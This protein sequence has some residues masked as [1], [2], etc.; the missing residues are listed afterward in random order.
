[1]EITKD[2]VVSMDYTL[3]DD[4]GNVLDSSEGREALSFVFGNGMIIPGLEKAIEGKSKGDSLKVSVEPAE[5]YG[6]YNEEA[7][8]SVNKDSFQGD[9]ELQVGMQVQAR[10]PN[11]DIQHL[12]ITE[13][14]GDNV[15]LDANHPLAGK[16]LHF[17]VTIADV[18]EASDEELEHGHAH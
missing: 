16:T 12:T 4:D 17:D 14:D 13:L 10:D 2:K 18:R 6:E 9:A 3:Q 15:T 5:A 11:G 8:V 7:T 1:M